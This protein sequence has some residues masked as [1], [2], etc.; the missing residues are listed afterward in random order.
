MAFCK[1]CGKQIPEGGS[2]DYAASKS[3]EE[4]KETVEKEVNDAKDTAEKAAD[5]VK[6]T[7][8]ELK[9]KAGEV[10]DKVGR[11]VRVVVV[12]RCLGVL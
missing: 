11:T 10:A 4:V 9:E 3:A 8:S 5:T 6:D 12:V 1:Y 2:C 7:A